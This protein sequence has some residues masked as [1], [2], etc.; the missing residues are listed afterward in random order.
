[1]SDLRNSLAQTRMSAFA[2]HGA[3][4][5]TTRRGWERRHGRIPDAATLLRL[6][7][8]DPEFAWLSPLTTL[9]ASLDAA[10]HDASP[11]ALG[12]AQRLAQAIVDLLRADESGSTFQSRYFRELNASP[13]LAVVAA[14]ARPGLQALPVAWN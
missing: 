12:R 1:M 5:E 3:L 10:L 11:E 9:I 4:L 6:L 14:R 7:T 13:D 2:V 8:E